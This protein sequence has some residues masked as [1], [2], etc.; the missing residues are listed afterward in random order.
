MTEEHRDLW[1][2][3]PTTTL[4]KTIQLE[5]PD[6]FTA[7][8]GGHLPAVQVCYE[9]WG[10]LNAARDNA[11][12]VVHLLTT[13]PHVTGGFAHQPDGWWERLIGPGRPIDTN[14]HFVICPNLIGGCH[15]TT[16][17]RFPAPDG[18]PY[19]DRF[20]LLAPVDMMRVQQLLLRQLGIDRLR[21]VIGASMGGMV[22]WEWAIEAGDLVDLAV[23]VAAPL[24]TTALQIGL[25]WLQRRGIEL[26]TNG[27]EETARWGQM[28]ARGVGML[29]YRS[30]V[31]LEEKFGREWF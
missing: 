14:N 7:R 22:A 29:S 27:D 10:E 4:G 26:D 8:G 1:Q 12:L 6:G 5:L 20:P 28:V 3:S 30:P 23:V 13:D 16:G 19:L 11:V 24:R 21:T 17:P 15:G 9:S 25:N 2:M 18:A 31:G